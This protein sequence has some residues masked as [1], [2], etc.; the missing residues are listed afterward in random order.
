MAAHVDVHNSRGIETMSFEEHLNEADYEHAYDEDDAD[1]FS[2]GVVVPAQTQMYVASLVCTC[3]SALL[4]VEYVFQLYGPNQ[5]Y[6][7][8][9]RGQPLTPKPWST[10][11][12]RNSVGAVASGFWLVGFAILVDWNVSIIPAWGYSRLSMAGAV[13][14]VVAAVLLTVQ[15]WSWLIDHRFGVAGVGCAWSNFVAWGFFTL[16]S[17]IDAVHMVRVGAAHWEEGQRWRERLPLCGS[18][19]GCAATVLLCASS[20]S[21]Y[22]L[23]PGSE[24][25][26]YNW[27]PEW[28]NTRF[29]SP[30]EL[31][32]SVLLLLGNAMFTYWAA[33]RVQQTQGFHHDD[34]A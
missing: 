14:R 21:A 26:T 11:S 32:G 5:R 3:A 22:L 24:G 15:P 10:P 28:V 25:G 29:I 19:F 18:C 20:G 1:L 6:Y 2:S 9:E 27:R 34:Y 13:L 4:F 8:D 31:T 7:E 30:G 17:C 33:P 23:V 16:G 12:I